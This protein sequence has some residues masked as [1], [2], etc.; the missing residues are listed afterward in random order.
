M[1]TTGIDA[2]TS[3]YALTISGR[4]HDGQNTSANRSE[5]DFK[6]L[7]NDLR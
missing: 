7:A 3:K 5:L 4:S 6:A 2:M 1:L